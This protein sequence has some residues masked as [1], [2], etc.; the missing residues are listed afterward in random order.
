[1]KI[2][3]DSSLEM[4]TTLT[5]SRMSSFPALDFGM[6]AIWW[7]PPLHKL[8]SVDF[9]VVLPDVEVGVVDKSIKNASCRWA[10]F[11]N[12]SDSGKIC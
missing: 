2:G 6:D 5:M 3:R 1:M 4:D 8:S 11:R 7:Q 10:K 12:V 9:V